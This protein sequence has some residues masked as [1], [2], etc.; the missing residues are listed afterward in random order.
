MTQTKI[1]NTATLMRLKGILISGLLQ[2]VQQ[3]STAI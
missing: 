2:H 1:N 3:L